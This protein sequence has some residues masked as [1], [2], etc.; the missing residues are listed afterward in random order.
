M[1]H[2]QSL[3][4]SP[5]F[6]KVSNGEVAFLFRHHLASPRRRRLLASK[7]K[8]T[9]L[10]RGSPSSQRP[11]EAVHLKRAPPRSTQGARQQMLFKRGEFR[12][13]LDHPTFMILRL[14][15]AVLFAALYKIVPNV[16]LKWSD[17]APAGAMIT[18]LLL[19]NGK[20]SMTL[21][22]AHASVGTYS[23][24]DSPIVVLLWAYYSA[25]LFFLGAEF[26]RVYPKTVR[27]QRDR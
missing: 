6:I 15:I 17:V 14:V 5:E 10:P 21:Y 26:S 20:Q 12:L 7:S 3:N 25:Q 13:V 4:Q 9:P 8:C 2:F 16:S 22:F 23:A 27:S 1:Q 19:M 18:S 24:A 11:P